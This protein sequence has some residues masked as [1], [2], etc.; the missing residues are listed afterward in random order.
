MNIL[1]KLT[2]KINQVK[3]YQEKRMYEDIHDSL[4][5]SC[6]FVAKE[7]NNNMLDLIERITFD[8][9]LQSTYCGMICFYTTLNDGTIIYLFRFNLYENHYDLTFI[10]G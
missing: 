1:D 10:N 7:K 2:H 3:D 8:S 6:K 9:W 5:S 4:M